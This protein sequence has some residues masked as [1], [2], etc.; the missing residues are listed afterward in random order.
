M[1][2]QSSKAQFTPKNVIEL[3]PKVTTLN[4]IEVTFENMG[5]IILL[6]ETNPR[7]VSATTFTAKR[8]KFSIGDFI[9]F[10][11]KSREVKSIISK[12]DV[13][14]NYEILTPKA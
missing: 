13:D 4:A 12:K 9:V 1:T 8:M 3:R 10:N 5:S 11:P 14:A 7:I 2:D 6:L